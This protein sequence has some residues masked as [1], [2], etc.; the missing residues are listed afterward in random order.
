MAQGGLF[1]CVPWGTVNHKTSATIVYS[2]SHCGQPFNVA[3]GCPCY[4]ARLDREHQ[5]RQPQ[6]TYLS[7]TYKQIIVHECLS[8]GGWHEMC[9]PCPTSPSLPSDDLLWCED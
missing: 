8:C 5:A 4:G 1:D 9:E 3:W 7:I 2:C 6:I